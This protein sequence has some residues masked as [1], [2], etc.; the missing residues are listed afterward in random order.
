MAGTQQDDVRR[1]YAAW[2]AQDLG[3]MLAIA[4]PDIEASPTLGLLYERSV[5]RGH[6]GIRAWFD[7]VSRGWERFDPQVGEMVERDGQV[8]AFIHLV[9][10]RDGRDFEAEIAVEHAFRDGRILT[11]HGRDVYEVR[12]ELGLEA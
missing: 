9:A 8:I 7:E 3:T 12:E 5:Y 2:T 11:L 4:H 1:Y 10:W 6:D